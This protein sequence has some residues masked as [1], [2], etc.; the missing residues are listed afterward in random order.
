[1]GSDVCNC[2]VL[3]A[4]IEES[5]S[6]DTALR[7][8]NVTTIQIVIFTVKAPSLHTPPSPQAISHTTASLRNP[9]FVA[10][11]SRCAQPP[12]KANGLHQRRLS[13]P[14]VSLVNWRNPLSNDPI[15]HV[16]SRISAPLNHWSPA[17]ALLS[18]TLD[19]PVDLLAS[20]SCTRPSFRES[21]D[22]WGSTPFSGNHTVYRGLSF[23]SHVRH[24]VA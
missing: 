21:A 20:C 18:P 24:G 4:A 1:M 5:S 12:T 17:G 2:R 6:S 19:R 16:P 9:D 23:A 7:P 3:I 13:L 11:R 8:D 14:A 10:A 15:V 22:L